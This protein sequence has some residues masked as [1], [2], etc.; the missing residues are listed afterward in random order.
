MSEEQLLE[1]IEKCLRRFVENGGN[2]NPDVKE[3]IRVKLLDLMRVDDTERKY[4][5]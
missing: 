2:L 4:D 1:R 3:Y 5:E